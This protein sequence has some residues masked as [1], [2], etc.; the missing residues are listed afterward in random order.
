MLKRN[1]Q[2]KWLCAS[3]LLTCL[4]NILPDTNL[5]N[6]QYVNEYMQSTYEKAQPFKI[7]YFKLI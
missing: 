7:L 3:I 1:K 4:N 2:W 6:N 5:K